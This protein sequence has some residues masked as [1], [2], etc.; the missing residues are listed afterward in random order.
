[1]NIE[2]FYEQLEKLIEEIN[3]VIDEIE[4]NTSA[5]MKMIPDVIKG[6]QE[7]LPD[8]FFFI[9]QTGIG[10]TQIILD[11]LTDISDGM[12]NEDAVIVA[13]ALLY[14]MGA[15]MAEYRDIIKEALDG[16]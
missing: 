3:R 8:W 6:I 16:E 1:M 5:G 4:N 11:I 7:L 15:L 2:L 13:D 9:E 10:E 12:G 14:G